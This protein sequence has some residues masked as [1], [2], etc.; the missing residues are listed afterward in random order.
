MVA[1]KIGD[2]LRYID[3]DEIYGDMTFGK[4]YDVHGVNEYSHAIIK[5]NAGNKRYV[6]EISKYFEH[7]TQGAQDVI[8]A[9]FVEASPTVIDLLTN[10]SRR[11]YELERHNREQ[12]Y[13]INDLYRSLVDQE[14]NR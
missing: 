2:K 9:T 14:V 12:A 4:E 8:Q 6:P 5:D 10:L 7:V 13:E 1:F 11:V 3:E